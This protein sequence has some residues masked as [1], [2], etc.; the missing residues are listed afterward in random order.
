MNKKSWLCEECGVAMEWKNGG[1]FCKCPSCGAEVW[2]EGEGGYKGN[3]QEAEVA[4]KIHGKWFC[5]KC[6]DEMQP[7]DGAFCKCP[8]CGAEVWYGNKNKQFEEKEIK[9]LMDTFALDGGKMTVYEA[10]IGGRA[11]KGKGGGSHTKS[12]TKKRDQLKKPTTEELYRRLS[13]GS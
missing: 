8:S 10:M 13:F 12:R 1:D 9:E 4:Q 6:R 5:Q 7:I 11:A 3:Q 2:E